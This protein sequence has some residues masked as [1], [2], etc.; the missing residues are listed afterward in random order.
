MICFGIWVGCEGGFKFCLI[1]GFDEGMFVGWGIL[2]KICFNSGIVSC[3]FYYV[4]LILLVIEVYSY[5][6]FFF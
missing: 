3:V 5:K 6:E 2:V 4:Y 1:L